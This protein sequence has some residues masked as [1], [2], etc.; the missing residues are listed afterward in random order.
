MELREKFGFFVLAI[1]L[2]SA[3]L[4][5]AHAGVV[6]GTRQN[7]AQGLKDVIRGESVNPRLVPVVSWS[8]PGVPLP[9]QQ[10]GAVR[11]NRD[12]AQDHINDPNVFGDDWAL[13]SSD[14]R[15]N[16]EA[17]YQAHHWTPETYGLMGDYGRWER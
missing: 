13:N 7:M 2:I 14:G 4:Y 17:D 3:G 12:F 16:R 10:G 6:T 1:G 8:V 9:P 15:T 11:V 5:I